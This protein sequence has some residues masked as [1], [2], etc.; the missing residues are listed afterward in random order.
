MSQKKK[1]IFSQTFG[2][3]AALIERDGKILLIKELLDEG[4]TLEAAAKKIENRMELINSAF[5]KFKA[6]HK[7]E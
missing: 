1:R 4:F 2:V 6:H 5:K 3:V 7:N